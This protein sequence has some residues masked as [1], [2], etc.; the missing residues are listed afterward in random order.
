[1]TPQQD[2]IKAQ[3]EITKLIE[4][5]FILKESRN[6]LV[7]RINA[8]LNRSADAPFN[9]TENVEPQKMKTPLDE[10]R[11]LASS[12]RQELRAAHL[13]VTR[14]EDQKMLAKLN[15]VPDFTFGFDYILVSDGQTSMINDGEDALIGSVSM[16]VPIWFNKLNAEV[17]E[18]T[19]LVAA[20]QKNYE[21]MRNDVRAE[22]DDI[23]FSI[24][25]YGDIIELHKTA[26]IPQTEQAF[27]A[28]RIGYESGSVDFLNWLDA[29]RTVLHTRLSYYRAI[30][31]YQKSVASLERVVGQRL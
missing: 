30:S 29:E 6:S 1:M 9:R 26:L 13:S 28:A 21:N 25:T 22:V 8:I 7:A 4:K 14:A 19:A 16:N 3:V 31:D 23:Y 2:V 11:E 15:Y 10:L 12:S 27:E 18:K 17:K 24:L 5:L 20:S